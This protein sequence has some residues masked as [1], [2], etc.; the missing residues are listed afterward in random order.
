MARPQIL[1]HSWGAK[2]K[3]IGAGSQTELA[4][5]FHKLFCRFLEFYTHDSKVIYHHR[6]AILRDV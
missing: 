2:N 5:G 1:V 3:D 4:R 6:A